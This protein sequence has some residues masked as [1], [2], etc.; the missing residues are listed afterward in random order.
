MLSGRQKARTVFLKKHRLAP[1]KILA[2]VSADPPNLSKIRDVAAR[3]NGAKFLSS[4]GKIQ[5]CSAA[6]KLPLKW[7]HRNPK[8]EFQWGAQAATPR[9][10]CTMKTLSLLRHAK[11]SWDDNGLSD[12][13][14]PLN[15]R[16]R[17]N[18]PQMGRF[19]AT[20]DCT[21]DL[22][23]CS[24]AKRA[25]QTLELVLPELTP[26]PKVKHLEQLYLASPGTL[27]SQLRGL[28]SKF[29]SV[30]I[31]AHNPGLH[32][33]ALGLTG[34]G[35]ETAKS[36]LARKFPTAALAVFS[37]DVAAWRHVQ[38]ARGDLELFVTPAHLE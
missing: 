16:G 34:S 9:Y 2:L 30:L 25:C 12:F 5:C 4:T 36:D 24:S 22:V 14:R 20:N 27:L 18:A 11:S 26:A 29:S 21:P 10:S 38:Q 32:A 31:V 28:S 37:F 19:M 7:S 15:G 3:L 6:K 23:L 17:R 8:A 35:N 33:L 13:E 1:Q